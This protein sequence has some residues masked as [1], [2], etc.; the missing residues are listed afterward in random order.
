MHAYGLRASLPV[1][2]L[3][4]RPRNVQAVHSVDA[5]RPGWQARLDRLTAR[6]VVRRITSSEVGALAPAGAE[7]ERPSPVVPRR[8]AP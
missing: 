3:P 2:L 4:R 8:S 1:R 5:H 7:N 6:R